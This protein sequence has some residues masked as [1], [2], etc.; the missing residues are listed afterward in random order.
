MSALKGKSPADVKPS[1]PKILIFG[2][3]GVGKT[4]G[5]LDFPSVYYIDTEGGANLGHYIDKLRKA[6]GSYLG[7]A[8]GANDFDVINEEI[9]TLA[10][11]KHSYRT[12]V[13]D[14][15]SKAFNTEVS[16]EYDRMSSRGRD[17]E[18]TFGAEKKTAINDL[19]RTIRW[20]EQLD[21][22]VILIAH[23]KPLWK[24]GKEVGAT[25]DAWDKL[26]YELHLS[27]RITAGGNNRNAT[28][29]KS[30][31]QE[32]KTDSMFPWSYAEFA[33]KYGRSI[34]EADTIP[35]KLASAE[36]IDAY[37]KLL[38]TVKVDEKIIEKWTDNCPEIANLDFEGMQK[39]IDYI[40]GLLNPPKEPQPK[41]GK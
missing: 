14:S 38:A 4:W 36:Q 30:R 32:F 19:R 9:A 24:D 23:E 18:K 10:T 28:V 15:L 3:P 7:P 16:A 21:M 31:L 39:R 26:E 13:I 27:L 17:M 1:K 29:C 5:S 12:L 41:K 34:I 20:F 11:T 22:N 40:K 35:A 6:G 2:R 25:F 33:D 37:T 8:D